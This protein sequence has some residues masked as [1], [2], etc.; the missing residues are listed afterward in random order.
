MDCWLLTGSKLQRI[1]MQ[2][3][4]V[5]LCMEFYLVPVSGH[6]A[7]SYSSQ[8]FKSKFQIISYGVGSGFYIFGL[9]SSPHVLT[10]VYISEE[11]C[12]SFLSGLNTFWEGF[13]DPFFLCP[14][15]TDVKPHPHHTVVQLIISS[16][17]CG[18]QK[19]LSC[20]LSVVRVV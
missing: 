6:S 13:R 10:A 2:S 1:G 20:S 7:C 18:M 19:C 9:I 5:C 4:F 17:N 3:P 12:S 11:K 15:A 16:F 8:N 14:L